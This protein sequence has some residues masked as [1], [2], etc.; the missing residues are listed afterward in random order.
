MKLHGRAATC[1]LRSWAQWFSPSRRKRS[2]SNSE[3]SE[4]FAATGHFAITQSGFGIRPFSILGGALQ[5]ADRV[6]GY[7]PVGDSR[8][9]RQT[10]GH[11][12]LVAQ[13]ADPQLAVDR[14]E[15]VRAGAVH[16][17][18]A[19]SMRVSSRITAGLQ[20]P[21]REMRSAPGRTA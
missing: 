14:N 17:D 2:R 9:L 18:D 4:R 11:R 16:R 13:D 8:E 12:T 20:L 21:A 10:D 19:I 1:L 15:M 6:E 7:R 5:V 3:D